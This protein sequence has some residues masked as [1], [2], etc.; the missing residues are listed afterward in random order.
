MLEILVTIY[1]TTV[2]VAR[3]ILPINLR[4]TRIVL[5]KM[6]IDYIAN[7]SDMAEFF[8]N[9]SQ[10]E[11]RISTQLLVAILVFFSLSSIQFSLTLAAKRR[12]RNSDKKI[13]S[14]L[15]L[16]FNTDIWS[17]FYVFI[18]QDFPFLF[19]RII[20]LFNYNLDE[21]YTIYFFTLKNFVLCLAELYRIVVIVVEHKKQANQC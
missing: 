4:V 14:F 17:L 21:H 6:V 10:S 9:L 3:W 11:A 2:L 5:S 12:K 15:D 13:N 20:I 8:S 16:I 7:A 1:L 18:F 19:L